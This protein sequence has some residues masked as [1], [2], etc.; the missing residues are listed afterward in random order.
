MADTLTVNGQTFTPLA[1][2]VKLRA[3]NAGNYYDTG[4]FGPAPCAGAPFYEEIEVNFDG[5]DG[6]YIVR[7][8][9]RFTPLFATLVLA[10]TASGCN[11]AWKTLAASMRQ[12]ARY[13]VAL[14]GASY[15]GCR[16]K[17]CGSPTWQ[18]MNSGCLLVVPCIWLQRSVA[19]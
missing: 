18:N 11:G 3:A 13:T 6:T 2:W 8:G 12:L 19:N 15:D 5:L 16:L 4:R 17:D 1:E 10:G 7:K 14:P 9:F